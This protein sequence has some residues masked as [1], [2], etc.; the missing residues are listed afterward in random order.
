VHAPLQH[1]ALL[2]QA[3]PDERHM[4]GAQLPSGPQPL[5][6]QSLSATQS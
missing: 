3:D 6:Q 1:A 5:L 4:A 2:A